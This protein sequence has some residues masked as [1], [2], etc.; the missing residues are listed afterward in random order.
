MNCSPLRLNRSLQF[1]AFIL[2]LGGL[3]EAHPANYRGCIVAKELQ[4]LRNQT[5]S[6]A[7]I[8]KRPPPKRMENVQQIA[9]PSS[10]SHTY[11]D[12]ASDGISK[13]KSNKSNS[14]N[15]VFCQILEKLNHQE[16]FNKNLEKRLSRLEQTLK[17]TISKKT[18]QSTLK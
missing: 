16:E 13:G 12:I 18:C 1:S 5:V 14:N 9:Q 8:S 7:N 3:Y 15:D 11:A 4:K 10:K 17:P 6:K 2:Y